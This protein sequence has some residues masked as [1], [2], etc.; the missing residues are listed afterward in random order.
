MP[1]YYYIGPW[2]WDTSDPEDPHYRPPDG[3]IGLIDL[4]P[5]ADYSK[6]LGFF[7]TSAPVPGAYYG[8]GGETGERMELVTT[9]KQDRWAV[10]DEIGIPRDSIQAVTLADVIWE[11][12]T[13][14]ADPES[15]RM[16]PPLMPNHR[17]E[18][19]LLLGGHSLI[20]KERFTGPDHPAWPN[21]RRMAQRDYKRVRERAYLDYRGDHEPT[22]HR[23]YLSCLSSKLRCPWQELISDGLPHESP[24]RPTTTINE[25]FDQGDSTTLGPDL[26]WTEVV[27]DAETRSNEA[28]EVGENG[29]AFCRAESN[30]SSDDMTVTGRIEG[31]DGDSNDRR[32]TG[33][34]YDASSTGVGD[35]E[36]YFLWVHSGNTQELRKVVAGSGSQLDIDSATSYTLGSD[37]VTCSA[38]GSSIVGKINSSTIT[39]ATDTDITGH[40]RTGMY[41]RNSGMLDAFTASDI[42]A[43]FAGASKIIG[44]GF[45]G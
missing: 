26:T 13:V 7:A 41:L 28:G 14:W 25:S 34:R 32:G 40:L 8:I 4:R 36:L 18:L 43:G 11:I 33:A 19:E 12:L 3:T 27:G 38:D 42:V 24:L 22:L 10:E 39:S 45:L 15:V 30:L 37:T 35:N 1:F 20:R 5:R 21:I 6:P 16:C 23:R 44:G 31:T 29:V 2:I 17:G 9:S